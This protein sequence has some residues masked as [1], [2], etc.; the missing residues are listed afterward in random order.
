VQNNASEEQANLQI[1]QIY[2][3]VQRQVYLFLGA[4]L[5]RSSDQPLPDLLEPT[6]VR[7]SSRH[8]RPSAAIWRK[9]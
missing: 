1:R 6:V 9:S 2:D 4:T 8:S 5:G 3:R 7:A